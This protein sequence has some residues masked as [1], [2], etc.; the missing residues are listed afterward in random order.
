M[1]G[2]L[3]RQFHG[4]PTSGS[5]SVVLSNICCLKMEFDVGKPLKPKL[6]KRY[7]HDIYIERAINQQDERFKKLNN[8]H[9]NIKLTIEVNPSKFSDTKIMIKNSIIETS[10]VVKESKVPNHWSSAVLKKYKRN[11]ILGHLHRAHKISSNFKFDAQR[12]KKKYLD[13][14]FPYNFIQYT[15]N[16]HQEKCGFLIPN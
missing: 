13:C 9:Q 2:R 7:V 5:I 3:I 16:S 14:N 1:N 4:C 15:F 12:I 11:T 10:V 8:Y 6:C